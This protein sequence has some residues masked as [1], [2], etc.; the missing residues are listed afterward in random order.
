[1]KQKT[2]FVIDDDPDDLKFMTDALNRVD[3]TIL[4]IT[5]QYPQEAMKLLT[6]EMITIPDFIF[7]DI[8]M[9]KITG[10]A[11]LR[12]LR[13]DAK[14]LKTPIILYSTSMPKEVSEKLLKAGAS[15]TFGKPNTENE[16]LV[17]LESIIFGNAMPSPYL[18][19]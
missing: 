14:F 8:N 2:V 13:T 17:V 7:I 12:Q 4:C 19:H 5:S 16:Y 10:D 15:F 3:S 18:Q 6:L 11:C 9:P 1:M